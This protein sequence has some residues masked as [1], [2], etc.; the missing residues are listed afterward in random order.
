[1]EGTRNQIFAVLLLA[2]L[3]IIASLSEAPM[4][5]S[6]SEEFAKGHNDCFPRLVYHKQYNACLCVNA[7]LF[8]KGVMFQT[9]QEIVQSAYFCITSDWRKTDQVVGGVCLY[10]SS[11][12]ASIPEWKV[13]NEDMNIISCQHLNRNQTLLGRC[14]ENHS[15]FINSYTF[16]CLPSSMC[17]T[18]NIMVFLLSTF[19]TLTSSYCVIF[20]PQSVWILDVLTVFMP[21]ICIN[22]HISNA[23]ATSLQC[24]IAFVPIADDMPFI[25]HG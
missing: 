3:L 20:L 8:G 14:A 9:N 2:P 1:M 19:G 16:Q 15:L 25:S 12:S 6:S 22:E 5:S 18:Q 4:H 7:T 23:Q 17:K 21:P 24:V 10:L 13:S 11:V